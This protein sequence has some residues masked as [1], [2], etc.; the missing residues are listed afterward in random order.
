MHWVD[1][2]LFGYLILGAFYGLR[3]GLVWVGFS[4]VGYIAGV[5]VAS[6]MSPSLTRFVTA[7]VPIRRW[8]ER[9]LPA[10]AGSIQGARQQAWHTAEDLVTILVFILIVGALEL[11]GR[12][13]G[14]TISRS[15]SALRVTSFLNRLGG[16]GAGVLEH[17]MV[18]GLVLTLILAI[19]AVGQSSLSQSIHHAVVA[20]L[21]VEAFHRLGRIPVTQ[22]L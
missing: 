11:V 13:V 18:A 3:R 8:V 7:A 17:G 4:L 16:I 1:I 14:S 2:V 9:Y 5:I 15:V 6:R 22:Y 20:Q 10:A 12:T 21:L 19:P